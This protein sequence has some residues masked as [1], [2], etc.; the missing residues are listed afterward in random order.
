MLVG[1]AMQ[2]RTHRSPWKTLL[3]FAIIILCGGPHLSQF[4]LVSAK[5]RSSFSRQC[6]F[7]LRGPL[8]QLE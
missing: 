2:A 1:I 5:F 4:A 8:L 3:A 6:G 7:W